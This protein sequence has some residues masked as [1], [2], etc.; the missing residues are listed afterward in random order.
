MIPP[1]LFRLSNIL[2]IHDCWLY[3]HLLLATNYQPLLGGS[4]I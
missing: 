4:H 3:P 2:F 1:T